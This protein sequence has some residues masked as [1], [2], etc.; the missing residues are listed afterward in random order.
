MTGRTSQLQIRVSPEQKAALKRLAAAAGQ[1]VSQYVLSQ[2]LPR[3]GDQLLRVLDELRGEDD[4]RPALATLA[5]VLA[6]LGRDD[7]ERS[8]D[9]WSVDGMT[10]LTQNRVMAL[11]EDLVASR[12]IEPPPSAATVAPLPR[13]HFRWTLD[14]LR[15]QQMRATRVVY[16]RRNLFDTHAPTPGGP[17][18]TPP[19]EIA[20]LGQHLA[21]LEL[22]V[23]FYFVA[24]A[25]I[26]QVFASRTTSARPRDVL[27]STP[28]ADP[29]GEF[30]TA[31]GWA[32]GS[33]AA[34]VKAIA[35]G[36]GVPGGFLE[37]PHVAVFQPPVE[38][39][40]ATKL[41]ALRPE[42]PHRDLEDLR[43]LLRASNLGTEEAARRAVSGYLAERHLPA[44][45]PAVLRSVLSG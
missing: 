39:A 4:C 33:V 6:G 21:I 35:G 18:P 11:I 19:R 26:H 15:P 28:E 13:P 43:F 9:S 44:H 38:Y 29:V 37:I 20:S 42:A 17:S 1:N 16:K 7:L 34:L 5:R 27:R 10:A 24:G 45:V 14:S 32:S 36:R 12:G 8:L 41:A 2:A 25:V 30:V 40:L 22:D 3:S 31:Q 23:E